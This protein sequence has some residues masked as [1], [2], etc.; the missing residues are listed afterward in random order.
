[1]GDTHIESENKIEQVT[2]TRYRAQIW[3]N[4]VGGNDGSDGRGNE[5]NMTELI[6]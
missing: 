1:V 6:R 3:V 5:A 4:Q 2:R